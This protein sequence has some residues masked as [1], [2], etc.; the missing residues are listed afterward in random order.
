[1]PQYRIWDLHC[2]LLGAQAD[3]KWFAG[4]DPQADSKFECGKADVVTRSAEPLICPTEQELTAFLVGKLSTRSL[5]RIERHVEDCSRCQT[6]LDQLDGHDDELLTMLAHKSATQTAD[7]EQT[8][9]SVLVSAR[10]AVAKSRV[11][12]RL[13]RQLGDVE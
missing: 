4:T 10:M 7:L 5:A 8:P 2:H 13:R 1:M 12:Q 6:S 3:R 9:E 11:L